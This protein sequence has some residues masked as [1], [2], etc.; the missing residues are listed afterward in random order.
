MVKYTV[1]MVGITRTGVTDGRG[2]MKCST[3]E[4]ARYA[5]EADAAFSYWGTVL[6]EDG[7]GETHTRAL[8]EDGRGR[9]S[10]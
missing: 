8:T 10:R 3:F 9:R 1:A 6:P 7:H 2:G 4:A 5:P